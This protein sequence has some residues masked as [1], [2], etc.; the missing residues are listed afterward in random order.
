MKRLKFT[1][2]LVL[3]FVYTIHAQ[4]ILTVKDAE[5]GPGDSTRIVI[6]L[7]NVDKISGFQFKIKVP[8]DL[9][10]NVNAVRFLGRNTNHALYPKALGNGEYL[11]L[12]F[13]ATGDD[14]K[15]Q[16]GD[17]IEIPVQL[18]LTYVPGQS[19]GITFTENILSSAAG[20]EIINTPKNGSLKVIEGKTPD[21]QTGSIT[22]VQNDILPNAKY[23]VSWNV[24]NIGKAAAVGGWLEQIS[25]VS[26]TSGKKYL[27]ANTSYS[28]T[29]AE[30]DVITRSIEV[31]V[32][33]II[34]FD[35][36]VKIEVTLITNA[37]VKEPATA[38]ANNT[39]LSTAANLLKRL[40]FTIDK[41]EIIE[42]TQ[43]NIR[44]N[45]ARSGDL[46]TDETFTLSSDADSR[47]NLPATITINKN[48]SSNFFYLKPV[49]NATYEGDKKITLL[50]KG[51]LYQ[52]ENVNFIL[53]DDEQEVLTLSY[54]SNYQSTIGSKIPFTLTVIFSK[55]EDHVITISSN[56]PQ[57]L[58]LPPQ[59]V[60][61]AGTK[62]IAFEGLVLD[63]KGIEKA[64]IA[65]ISAKSEGYTAAV[66]EI[67]LSAI[68]V[69]AFTLDI[70][71]IK[72]SEGDG[73]KATYATLKRSN[74]IDKEV[75]VQIK[76]NKPDQ[77]ILPDEILFEKGQSEKIFNI[78]TVDNGQVEGE[79]IVTVSSQIKFGSCSC[80]DDKDS[81]TIVKKDLTILDNDGLALAVTI[82]PSTVKAGSI[83][84]KLKL[85]RNSDNPV[86]LQN[87]VTVSLSSNLPSVVELPATATIAAGKKDTT[88]TFNTKIDPTLTGDQS[89][90]IQA[91]VSGY[92]SG[93]AW[94][95]VSDQN[96]ADAIIT[97]VE[98]GTNVEAGKKISVKTFIQNQGNA[99]FPAGYKI[100]YFLSK[101]TDIKDIK[102]FTTSIINKVINVGQTYEHTE[103]VQL[104][105]LSGNLYLITD[106]NSDQSVGELT[107][108]N[109]QNKVFIK[110][111]PAYTVTLQ[112]DK[113]IYKTGEV[114]KI[115]G[116]AKMLNGTSVAATEVSLKIKNQE[117]GRDYTIKTDV[118]GAFVFEYLPL[119]NESG[120]YTVAAAFP[121]EDVAPQESFQLLGFEILNKPQFVKWEPLVNVP[122][123]QEFLLKN[124]T[125]TKLTGVKIQLPPDADFTIDQ[126]P[127]DI[128]PN[129]TVAFP[130]K[131]I[132]S[133][134]SKEL[135]Y[136]NI[137]ISI[138]SAEGAVYNELIYYHS[139][140]QEAK[141]E[142]NPLTINT[143]MIKDQSRLYELTL[144]NTGA[145]DA[146]N[147]TILLP[148]VGWLKLNSQKTIERIK[149]NDIAKVVLELK[150]TVKE[151]V[152]VPLNGTLVVKQKAGAALSIPFNITTVSES[153]GK[154]IIDATD[155][156]TYNTA[157]APHLKGA[158]VVVKQPYTGVVVAE[159]L[160]NDMGLF[161]I[162]KIPEGWYTI[163]VSAEKHNPYQNN[164]LV[165]PGK[166]TKITSFLSY[167]AIT[168]VWD[169]KPTEVKDEYDVKLNVTFETNVPKPVIV[170]DV[171][172]PKLDLKI[173]ES[174]LSY[175]TI[176]NHG[177][178]AANKVSISTGETDGYSIKPLI[179]S[180]DVLNA[181]SSVVIPVLIKNDSS[182][183]KGIVERSGGG[184]CSVPINVRAVY[185]CDTE[186]EIFAF[187]VYVK[188][189]CTSEGHDPKV[190]IIGPNYP[191]GNGCTN[192]G[193]DPYSGGSSMTSFPDLCDPCTNAIVSTVLGCN[194]YTS[195]ISCIF[196]L[197]TATDLFSVGMGVASCV[198]PYVSCI[199][200][201]YNLKNCFP[202]GG[203]ASSGILR[204]ERD[205]GNF[206][207][208]F[209][210]FKKII[211]ADSAHVKM[212]S[213]YF[214][215]P[216]LE[217][218][219]DNLALFLK[220][221]APA[222]DSERVITSAEVTALKKAMNG[223]TV[224]AAY[225][226]AFVSKWNTTAEAWGKNILSPNAQY[227][228]I[229]DKVKILEYKK[230]KKELSV[231][232]FKKGFVSVQDMYASD[233][234]AIEDYQK[235]KSKD[236]ASVCASI[237]MEFPQK[238][239][240]TR[241]AFEG[242][243]K[244]N[245]S[246]SKAIKDINLDLVV[247]NATG[248][249]KTHLFQ[250][251]KDA[252]LSGTGVVN[253]NSN[254][255]GLVTF[256]PTSEVAPTVSQSYSF[257][258]TLSYFDPE[259]N[260]RVNITL[261]P[262]TLEVNPSPNLVLHYFM[263]R[264][265]LG[266]DAL[267]EATVE[268]SVPAQLALMIQNDGYGLAKNVNVESMQPKILDNEKGLLIDF[269]MIG[270]Q[271]N[272]GPKQ[273]GLLNID[274]GNIEPKKTAIGQW[275]FTSSLMGHFVKYDVKVTHKSS[276][277]NANLSLIKAAYIHE[278][279]RSVKSYGPSSDSIPD[280][281]VND[282][283][284]AYDTPDRIYLSDG[285]SEEVSKAKTI[286]ALNQVN[287]ANLTAKIK[288]AP[289]KTG[290]NYESIMDPGSNKYKLM[291]VIRD[292]DN[293]EIPLQN[294][295]QTDVTLKD[296]LNPKY[297]NKLH[298]LDKIS[299]I[300][301]Y[302]LYFNPVDGNIPAILA[303]VN[304]PEKNNNKPVETV[305]VKFNKEI[306]AKTFTNANI[307]L[308]SQ[309]V[310]LPS[311][312]IKISKITATDYLINV[313]LLTKS[314]GYYELLVKTLGVK[315]LL[316]NEGKDGK[317][318]EWLQFINELGILKFESDQ[319]KKQSVNTVKLVFNKPIRTEEFTNDKITINSKPVNS[320]SIQK[321]DEYNYSISGINVFNKD[322]GDY[323]LAIDVTK[324]TAVDGTKGL[325]LQTYAWKVDNNVPKIVKLQP[326]S[327]GAVNNQNITEIDIELNRK[328]VS[329]M[330]VASIKFTKNGQALA[331]PVTI[332]KVDD[333]HYKLLG[334]GSYTA[335]NGSYRVTIDQSGFKDENDNS[336]EGL[337]E[338][339]WTVKLIALN[340][341]SD[342]HITP[343]RGISGTDNITSGTDV[344]LVYKTVQD[345]LTV[346]VY[347]LQATSELLVNK[348]FR[349]KKGGYTV[350]LTNRNGA[351]KFKVIAFDGYGNSGNTVL[352]ST[353]IDFTDLL[354]TIEPVDTTS[355]DCIDFDYVNVTFSD[356]ITDSSFTKEAITLKS[357][358]VPISKNSL[359]VKKIAGNK[360]VLEN[361]E[362]KNGG[363][364]TIEI[365]KSRITKN[366]SGLKGS[367]IESKEIGNSTKYPV[368]IS[369][370]INPVINTIYMYTVNGTVNKYDWI[371]TNGEIISSASNAVTI[372]W[373]KLGAQ[374][375]VLR[376]QTP[377]GCTLLQTSDVVVGTTATELECKGF[378]LYDNSTNSPLTKTSIYLKTFNGAV[379][380]SAV[381]D[382]TGLYILKNVKNGTFVLSAQT[383]TGWGG[384]N[385]TDALLVKKYAVGLV[386]FS[387]L[388]KL[389]A[390][391]N[392]SSSI[393]ATDALT[394]SK[395]TIGLIS[396]F[397]AGDW[398]FKKDSITVN[399]ANIVHDLRGICIGDVNG[400]YVPARNRAETVSLIQENEL[401]I[402]PSQ[403]FIIP[404]KINSNLNVGAIT[405]GLTYPSAAFSVDSIVSKASGMLYTIN[406]GSIKMAWS[407]LK[408]IKFV[409]NDSIVLLMCRA[410]TYLKGD[411]NLTLI[412][413][414]EFADEEANVLSEVVLSAPTIK[415][416]VESG[417]NNEFVPPHVYLN[418][419]HPNPFG[420]TTEIEYGLTEDSHVTL[421]I[422]NLIGTQIAEIVNTHQAMGNYAAKVDI[423]DLAAGLYLYQLKVKG[424]HTNV[425]KTKTMSVSK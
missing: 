295:W 248:E 147:V 125:G 98:A 328:L 329:V 32:P 33:G 48:E 340:T 408:P 117:F 9:L 20:Q 372:K 230:I 360:Y 376:Y 403:A 43:D 284:D 151:Q 77:L 185:L 128:E 347:E 291:K 143:T 396:S 146:E 158:K 97:K 203:G 105:N 285:S 388:R 180:L 112:L 50:A 24:Q 124:K 216:D 19:Y 350:P 233:M 269:K 365:D 401:V 267:T 96:K 23:T 348:Q 103:E 361:I 404:V 398:V 90:R 425:I 17:L 161:E 389:S 197:L 411:F 70:K 381:S 283:S 193:L 391:V 134:A 74:Q 374:S 407:D 366:L 229:V 277:G 239:T 186:K 270:S 279:I 214:K 44:I 356:D 281:L 164:I 51:S 387:P 175:I 243:L 35:G 47:F 351:K 247:K 219:N 367:A 192:C 253:P 21:L 335:D 73:I 121:G 169:V 333:T 110:I 157:S 34:G 30:N 155:E 363:L 60:L 224:T 346:E 282:V 181:K 245:N 8:A 297:E 330:D 320:L 258:G 272:N 63:T 89:V 42:N 68:N 160:T 198:N 204:S 156:Y 195:T 227:P 95:L 123:G 406:N 14:L 45:L 118:N 380:D 234:K 240:M 61:K 106:V 199:W 213:E 206:N 141:L 154:L 179:T 274:F 306:D 316:G 207:F 122:L 196:G 174:R 120:S 159:G 140:G 205:G 145:V 236:G 357:S 84:N 241:Q 163:D 260:E 322:N 99:I 92:S 86:I 423:A 293:V 12:S 18:P 262:V 379:V 46:N 315:D 422:Y 292:K 65:T 323:S 36:S 142:A 93:F 202:A 191:G 338:A 255:Q 152:N 62:S 126:T 187:T 301:T 237:T 184:G 115:T 94:L 371:I 52:D 278:L 305:T 261:N 416:D 331:I 80:V 113:K 40:I 167:Q 28:S 424:E 76:A 349:E 235:E 319:V 259:K 71:P 302:T 271:F 25:L 310:K 100:N 419:N 85:S 75:L 111:L 352:L 368:L 57:R 397:P 369:G 171:D 11:F 286:E 148:E 256:I 370:E 252:F 300:E 133:I 218:S 166:D 383:N 223:T 341:L 394:I 108:D 116:E 41:S 87:P 294:F 39:A 1:L 107:Y 324:I 412:P 56:E 27:I 375:L 359:I 129:T 221:A 7:D 251:N 217:K 189:N 208:I 377:L 421:T 149:A 312:S 384:V 327:Q 210:D 268:P 317:K 362:N 72:V 37:G 22:L 188:V 78:G 296:G 342:V 386:Q 354:T 303:F 177:L 3:S 5:A 400:S 358:G 231:H 290:W 226:D 339:A 402:K 392:L 49:N 64:Q 170:M 345:S 26:Q 162:P 165:D 334:L 58:Q 311:D 13:S 232:A 2:L 82:S 66:K 308:I 6:S 127:I 307:E 264:D 378:T 54:P 337:A 344:Q 172:N 109:N 137:K 38:K 4:N 88:I 318:L 190:V 405:L 304:P 178:I 168:Y 280:F 131:I 104:P 222:I 101:T 91:E 364:I 289:S 130:F 225:I 263:Q 332:D 136:Y 183:N 382:S 139:K 150:P 200:A 81:T 211:D 254:A 144:K 321:T 418:Q 209:E 67:K 242:N 275:F 201:V 373:N 10:V 215:N 298:V 410:N 114:V 336:G 182:A 212:L 326:L 238:L 414:S 135:I 249:N 417:I 288:I 273:L 194:P 313:K 153:T 228:G 420:K 299:D 119:D 266:D 309:G 390:D 395:R 353:Y 385:S 31:D 355:N 393:N 244:I 15:G 413:G 250:I 409:K 246:S 16:T 257:G 55:S 83:N 132:S 415:Y 173:G 343:D 276:F 176:T 29:L 138:T 53:K 314:S 399:G 59:V 287:A 69:P 79:K 220:V 102:P 265:I 325:A